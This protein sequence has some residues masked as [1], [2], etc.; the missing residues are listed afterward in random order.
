[1]VNARED[2]ARPAPPTANPLRVAKAARALREYGK[3]P[4]DAIVNLPCNLR[5]HSDGLDYE[6]PQ[7]SPEEISA[8]E[9]RAGL[10]PSFFITIKRVAYDGRG[11]AQRL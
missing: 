3:D 10:T 6:P 5:H 7:C 2:Y 11:G 4:F 1:M 9:R 8:F